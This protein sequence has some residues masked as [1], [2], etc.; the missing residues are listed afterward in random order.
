MEKKIH[1]EKEKLDSNSINKH[2]SATKQHVSIKNEFQTS[3][4]ID[5]KR[6][7]NR[8]FHIQIKLIKLM[9][10]N[11]H[12]TGNMNEYNVES[13]FCWIYAGNR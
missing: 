13:T 11:I 7:P 6:E 3:H 1:F 9:R 12:K 10:Q 8:S 4:Y 5:T 2:I